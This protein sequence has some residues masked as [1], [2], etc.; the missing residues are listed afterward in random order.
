M[1]HLSQ[2]PTNNLVMKKFLLIIVILVVPFI[3]MA[4]TTT[5]KTVEDTKTTVKN[6]VAIKK[7]EPI[8]L[9][10]KTQHLDLNY[11]KSNDIISIKAYIKSLQLK[12]KETLMS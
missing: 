10:P 9:N 4:Q 3:S 2:K 1:P 6:E 7:I 8:S 5:I 12:R 11:K